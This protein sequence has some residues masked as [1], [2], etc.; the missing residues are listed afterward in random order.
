M[1]NTERF[2][3]KEHHAWPDKIWRTVILEKTCS[4]LQQKEDFLF[5]AAAL[6]CCYFYLSQMT[7]WST[8]VAT[9]NSLT[10]LLLDWECPLF[11]MLSFLTV[12]VQRE[13]RTAINLSRKCCC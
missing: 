2:V 7:F 6:Q 12:S 10:M 4:K 1:R 5:S 8:S 11:R 9:S 3:I 13:L